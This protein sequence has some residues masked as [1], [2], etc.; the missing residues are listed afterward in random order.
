MTFTVGHK[1]GSGLKGGLASLARL[2]SNKAF[3]RAVAQIMNEGDPDDRQL[4]TRAHRLALHMYRLAMKKNDVKAARFLVERLEGAT[5]QRVDVTLDANI[6][7]ISLHM[8]TGEASQAYQDLLQHFGQHFGESGSLLDLPETE[9]KALP[10][11]NRVQS[12][13]VIN[14]VKRVHRDQS[15]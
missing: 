5:P 11:P 7:S 15:K 3:S 10:E 9:F 8:A 6:K 12:A 14:R 2:N 4:R 13:P 1:L